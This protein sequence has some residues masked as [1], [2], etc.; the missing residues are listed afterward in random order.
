MASNKVGNGQDGDTV[1]FEW[2]V[3]MKCVNFREFYG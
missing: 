3:R 1:P 2:S